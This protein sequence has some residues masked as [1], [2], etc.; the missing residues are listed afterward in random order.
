MN[1]IVVKDLMVPL[2]EYATVPQ[3]ATLHEAVLALEK[4]QIAVDPSQYK[5][6]AV[7]VLDSRNHIVG[8]LSMFDI[9][10]ALEPKYAQLEAEGV[11][12]RSGYSP[13][14]IND[15]LKDNALWSQP[16]QFI[17]SRAT[18]LKVA[19]F[20]ETPEAGVY[21]DENATLGEAIHQMVMLQKHS[22]LVTG[23]EGPAGI[24]RLSDVFKQICDRIKACDV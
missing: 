18:E 3:G 21:I 7:L 17:C 8:K 5:H 24:L 12:S 11:L 9:L 4:A 13:R 19:D 20:M 23:A 2:N 6:R 1:T 15:L 14:F 10:T 16:L 22:L